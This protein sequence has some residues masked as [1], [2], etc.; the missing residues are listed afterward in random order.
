[1]LPPLDASEAQW[2]AALNDVLM[3][4]VLLTQAI[5]P[6]MVERGFGRVINITSGQVTAPRGEMVLSAAPRAALTAF[7]KGLSLEV[8]QHDVVINN[9]LPERFATD[10][11]QEH[12]RRVAAERGISFEQAL[13]ERGSAVAAKRLGEPAEFGAVCAFYCSAHVGY[14]SGQNVHLDGGAYPGLI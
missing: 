10:R 6:G 3:S 8:M 12:A 5:V 11:Q 7:M 1:V 14:M 9:L 2:L 4:A 13:R